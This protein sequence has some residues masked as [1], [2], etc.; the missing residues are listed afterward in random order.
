MTVIYRRNLPHVHPPRATF[1]VTFRLAGSLPQE[2]VK[3]LREEQQ[4]EERRLQER[5]SGAALRQER[6]KLHKK[7]FGRYDDWLDQMAHGP[8]WLNDPA[9]AE[10][11]AQEIRRLDEVQCDIIAYCVMP[12]HVHLLLDL[13]RFPE[14]EIRGHPS[15]LSQVLHLLKGRTARY[16]NQLLGRSGAFWQRE[17]YDH[18]V[19]DS[20]EL[21][22][23]VRYILDNPVKAGLVENWQDWPYTYVAQD[24]I[25]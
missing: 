24:F 10:M 2:V 5:L 17:S 12:N 16:A 1:F 25:P 7:F 23:I 20:K 9:L 11:V 14:G 22:R 18:F 19:R 3:H 15:A 13:H 21:E 4:E 8:T 6:Y